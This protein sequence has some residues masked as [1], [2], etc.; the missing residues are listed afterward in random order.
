MFLSFLIP[1][2]N[3]SG[4]RKRNLEFIYQRLISHFDNDEIEIIFGIQDKKISKYYSQF[5]KAII[6][7]CP[8][9][10]TEV[11]NK[12]YIFNECI[13]NGVSG[14]YLVFLDSDVY[15]SYRE[16][17]KQLYDKKYDVVKPF[18]ECVFL[19]RE[20]TDTFIL[21]KQATA[22]KDF[23]RVIETGACCLILHKNI[24]PDINMDENFNGWGWED[25]DFANQLSMKYHIHTINQ[26]AIHLYHDP[27]PPNSNNYRY[28]KNKY[29][30]NHKNYNISNKKDIGI[31]MSYFSPCNF[32]KPR[33]NLYETLSSLE[34]TKCPVTLIEAIMPGSE[35]LVLPDWVD[36]HK[37][38]VATNSIL[39]LKENLYNI[40]IKKT[41]YSKILFL[42]TDIL[43]DNPN[44]ID[45]SSS[46]LDTYDVIQ[47][48]DISIWMNDDRLPLVGYYY[49][50]SFAKGIY[51]N[52]DIDRYT[53][54]PGF[55]WGMT[56]KFLDYV[57]GLYDQHPVGGSDLAFGYA[58][59]PE[60]PSKSIV[61]KWLNINQLWINTNKYILY[62]QR[63]FDFGPKIGYLAGC[64]CRH[65]YHGSHAKRNY[66]DRNKQYLPDLI[67]NDYP[68]SYN[69]DG[70]LEWVN[71]EHGIRC[72]EYFKSRD[73]DE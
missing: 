4:Y 19:D 59:Y 7:H 34:Q 20:T 68:L 57:G 1:L 66:I 24:L 67:D 16:L 15:F 73:E 26:Q 53:Y 13:R 2:Y 51:N 6:K 52:S 43:F 10:N 25:I 22:D 11:F 62:K 28:F 27:S 45:D 21:Y 36:H 64:T 3:I 63:V 31:I 47:P 37:F 49:K 41:N 44:F 33:K 17:K 29:Q 9:N 38:S 12:S 71:E 39:F 5:D 18:N 8:I 70:I 56:R 32:Q 61:E 65:L 69:E 50:H 23:K 42:D 35:P 48:Y 58:I 55:A 30:Y 72:L 14:D 46:L 54:H 60:N 40:G